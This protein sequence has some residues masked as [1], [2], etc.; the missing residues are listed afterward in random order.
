VFSG[1]HRRWVYTLLLRINDVCYDTEVII[2]FSIEIAQPSQVSSNPH[3]VEAVM[4]AALQKI[5]TGLVELRTD[6]GPVYVSPSFWER[7]YL[8]WTFRNFHRLPKQV[9]NDHQRHLI[10]R[11]CR[12]AIVSRNGPTART[13]IIG[14]VE[15]V[16][17]MPDCKLEAAATTSKLVE[18]STTSADVA[19]P[20]AVGSEGISIRSSRAGYKRRDVGGLRR[21]RTNV[22]CISTPKHDSAEQSETKEESSAPVA[23]DA[24]TRRS[25][26]KLAWALLASCGAV[27]LVILFYFREGR[28]APPVSVLRITVE[29]HQPASGNIP[30]AA[31]APPTRVQ[32]LVPAERKLPGSAVALK[33]PSPPVSS[34]HH[35]SSHGDTVIRAQP[36][37]AAAHSTPAEPLQV[38]EAPESG[39]SYPVTP[40]PTLTGKVSLKAVIRADGTVR[41]VDV[42]S[43]NRT[44]ASAAVQAVRH[45]RYRRYELKGHAVEA[46]TN[47]TISFIGDEAVSISFP[48]AH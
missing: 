48:P 43:G 17:L 14:A 33:L 29:G 3:G 11:L 23:S 7:I 4:S 26:N 9:L 13:S 34:G 44:L 2:I 1:R 24:G 20:R 10:D 16:Y 37:V 28:L 31:V 6:I 45:W 21:R 30:S 15:N 46:E 25:Q 39:F 5:R 36:P 32:L 42:L 47:I 18:L 27:L 8:L 22:Q 40:N 41:E 35:K 38:A 19:A 12:S